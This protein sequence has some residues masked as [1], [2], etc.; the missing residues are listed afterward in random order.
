MPV[1]SV[2]I[3]ALLDVGFSGGEVVGE[4]NAVEGIDI[5]TVSSAEGARR[6]PW[7]KLVL[8]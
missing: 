7:I 5:D 6:R 3:P 4:L 1:P 2:R 8:A